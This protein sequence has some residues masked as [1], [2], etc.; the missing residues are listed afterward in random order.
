MSA[1]KS[2]THLGQLRFSVTVGRK[3]AREFKTAPEALQKGIEMALAED[4][5]APALLAG[6]SFESQV[7]IIF[8]AETR[9]RFFGQPKEGKQQ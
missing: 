8:G 6:K 1:I 9:E 5:R 4:P 7:G 3:S 2:Y